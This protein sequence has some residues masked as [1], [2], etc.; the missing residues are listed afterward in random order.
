VEIALIRSHHRTLSQW[1]QK[2]TRAHWWARA[3]VIGVLAAFAWHLIAPAPDPP[4]PVVED[5]PCG[6]DY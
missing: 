5:V 2:H 4:P 1:V 3:A 6:E